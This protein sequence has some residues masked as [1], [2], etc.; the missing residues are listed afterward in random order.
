MYCNMVGV[1][2]NAARGPFI[3]F[4]DLLKARNFS[5]RSWIWWTEI[6]I[7]LIGAAGCDYLGHT[8]RGI[9]GEVIK[10]G[11][12]IDWMQFVPSMSSLVL[13][14]PAAAVITVMGVIFPESPHQANIFPHLDIAGLKVE[15]V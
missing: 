10:L 5:F 13:I 1:R 2:R 9:G 4:D 14:P 12:E 3:D 11:H 7:H 15:R 6:D 8:P